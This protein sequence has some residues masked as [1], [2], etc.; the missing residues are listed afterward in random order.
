[1]GIFSKI[2]LDLL[3]VSI[4]EAGAQPSLANCWDCHPRPPIPRPYD[5]A[6]GLIQTHGSIPS[7]L[8]SCIFKRVVEV[9]VKSLAIRH[10]QME[11]NCVK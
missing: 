6:E 2:Y 10:Q 1:M 4:C 5:S 9:V 3:F 11:M 7:D 8:H